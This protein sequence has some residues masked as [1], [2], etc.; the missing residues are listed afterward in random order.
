MSNSSDKLLDLDKDQREFLQKVSS[1]CGLD[2]GS[3][4]SLWEYTVF[5]ILLDIAENPDKPYNV[6]QIPFMGKI[7]FKESKEYPGEYDTFLALSETFKNLAKK[8]KK[9]DLQNIIDYYSEK[10]VKGTVRQLEQE[11]N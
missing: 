5:A 8:V 2:K 3:V 9:G 11:T 4:Q 1:Y 6:I 7:L 10:F